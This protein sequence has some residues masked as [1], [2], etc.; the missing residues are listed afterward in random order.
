MLT[1]IHIVAKEQ[2]NSRALFAF[3]QGLV[4]L[5]K[6]NEKQ[7]TTPHCFFCR[8][9]TETP[10]YVFRTDQPS[11][12]TTLDPKLAVTQVSV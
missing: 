9:S 6:E 1:K 12:K 11:K 5:G 7:E 8:P 4:A 3:T 2:T 10:D